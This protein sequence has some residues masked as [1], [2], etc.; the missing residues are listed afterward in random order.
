LSSRLPLESVTQ[1]KSMCT[2]QAPASM[3]SDAE[4]T[5]SSTSTG[6]PASLVPEPARPATA[7][8]IAMVSGTSHCGWLEASATNA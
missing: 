6:Y 3:T 5:Y 4:S 8:L 7:T 2:P 1:V